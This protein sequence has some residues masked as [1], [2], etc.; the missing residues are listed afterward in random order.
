M[1]EPRAHALGALA[2]SA[3]LLAAGREANRHRP[4]L[5]PFDRYGHRIDEVV[6]HPA[7][8]RFMALAVEHELHSLPWREPR[9]AAR[10]SPARRCS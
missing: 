6:Y 2:G 9:A 10:T 5:Q 8:H 7:Y 4:E 1:A 3:E